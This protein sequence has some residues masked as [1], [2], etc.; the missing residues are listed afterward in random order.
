M[1]LT[2]TILAIA[3][4]LALANTEDQSHIH[5][6]VPLNHSDYTCFALL[7]SD[8]H[9]LRAALGRDNEAI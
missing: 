1:C 4:L 9:A 8:D 5:R 6:V 7:A 3:T 2:L